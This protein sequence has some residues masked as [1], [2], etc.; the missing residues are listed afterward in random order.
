MEHVTVDDSE[1]GLKSGVALTPWGNFG[2][3]GAPHAAHAWVNA[4]AM[5]VQRVW[6]RCGA[7]RVGAV[8]L[9]EGLFWPYVR[10]TACDSL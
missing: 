5:K 3:I 10:V 4:V 1:H 2:I 8:R 6:A 9:S 7:V